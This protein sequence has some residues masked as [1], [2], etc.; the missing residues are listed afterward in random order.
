MNIIII[1]CS[2]LLSSAAGV[3]VLTRNKNKWI[4]LL[5]AFCLNSIILIAATWILYSVDEE[6]KLFGVSNLYELI[7]PIPLLIWVHYF[8]LEIA[9]IRMQ[10]V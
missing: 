1:L 7:V 8:I 9:R 5:M 10:T 3:W 6:A 4:A 2:V